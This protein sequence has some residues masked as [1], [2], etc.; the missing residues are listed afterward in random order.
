MDYD[1]RIRPVNVRA[2]SRRAGF[3]AAGAGYVSQSLM[4]FKVHNDNHGV[5]YMRLGLIE[6][7][8]ESDSSLLYSIV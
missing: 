8:D 1:N 7:Y 3:R 6:G 5:G 4:R 2:R